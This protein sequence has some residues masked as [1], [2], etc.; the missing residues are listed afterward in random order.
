MSSPP[1]NRR[2]EIPAE[3]SS[4]PPRAA[5][6]HA[7]AIIDARGGHGTDLLVEFGSGRLPRTLATGG[8]EHVRSHPAAAAAEHISLPRC[9][10][11]PGLVNAH[12][13]LDL[14]HIGPRPH[15]P[16]SGFVAWVE[17][18][19]TK[20]RQ[21]PDGI[22]ASVRRGIELCLAGGTVAV[23]D[24]AGAFPGDAGLAPWRTLRDS[25]L[26]GVSFQELF[27]IGNRIQAGLER[28]EELA[29]ALAEAGAGRLSRMGLQPHAPYSVDLRLYR[30]AVRRALALDLP[31]A[32]HLAESPEERQF[33]SSAQGPL[34]GF[35]S[36]LGIFDP[37][38]LEHLGRGRDPVAHLEPVL[39]KVPFTVAH[40]N[41]ADDH[42][43]DVLAQTGTTVVY[44]PRASEYF[45]AAMHF[46]PH[47][48]RDMIQAGV[49]VALGTDSVINLPGEAA[50]P[51]Q[52][53][54]SIFDEMRLLHQRDSADP[55]QLL[56]MAT[57]SGAR[58]LRMPTEWFTF[59]PGGE[60]AG[61]IA[62]PLEGDAVMR[63]A[64]L[65]ALLAAALHSAAQ[66]RL[67]LVR[68][69]CRWR[70]IRHH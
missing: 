23:G 5:L 32:T 25:T 49:T 3:T 9:L 2:P 7:A 14:T 19:R 45:G 28:L 50:D 11:L 26:L 8:T 38:V 65:D 48:Y 13:H 36:G 21:D 43:I 60:L 37:S 51:D 41:H 54:M 1:Q 42:A 44:C 16:A 39:R 47:R 40:V 22:A 46:G 27:G 53:G 6:F 20:R 15:D 29:E 56:A 63:N 34:R 18:I 64:G 67:L 30:E 62:V 33:V 35:L 55:H 68:N 58:A 66:P 17:M 69:A 12:T 57:T 24:I 61:A 4:A 52:R 70:G 10:I 31:I 59:T